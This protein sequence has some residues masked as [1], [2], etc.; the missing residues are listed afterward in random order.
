MITQNGRQVGAIGLFSL[1]FSQG[2]QRYDNAAL[3][4][5]VPASP[6]VTFTSD[7]IVQG[8]V[9][10]SN[11]NAVGEMTRLIAVSRAFENLQAAIEEAQNAQKT[12]IQTLA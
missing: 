1:D 5:A 9:E 3:I 4:P 7:G 8:Y 12:A 11:V 10:E 6:V 2:Y